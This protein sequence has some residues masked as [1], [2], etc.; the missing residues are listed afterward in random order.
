[1]E[2]Q[3]QTSFTFEIDNFSEKDAAISSPTFSTGRFQWFVRVHPKGDDVDDHLSLYLRVANPESLPLGWKRR[4][5]ISFALLNQSGKEIFRKDESTSYQLFCAQLSGW[6]WANAVPLK[7]LQEEGFLEKNKLRVKVEVKVVEVVDEEDATGNEMFQ[8]RGFHVLYS[9]ARIVTMLFF[10]HPDIAVNVRS[11]NQLVKTTYMNL[12][13]GLIETLEKPTHSITDSELS[14]AHSEL[15][16]LTDVAGFKLDWLKTKLNEVSLERKKSYGDDT[17]VQELEEHIKNLNV[18]LDKEKV[19]STTSA[20]K[21][22]SLEQTVSYLTNQMSGLKDDVSDLKYEVSDLRDELNKE[23]TSSDTSAA[24]VWSLEK[25][26]SDL[27][28][29]VSDLRDELN[30]EKTRSD[31]FSAEVW[32]LEQTVSDLKDEVSDLK[33]ALNKEEAKSVLSLEHTVLSLRDELKKEETKSDTCAAKVLSLEQTVSDLKDELNKEEAKS[34]ICA[35]KYLSLEQTVS[36]LKDELNK[37]KGKSDTS[38][39][40]VLSLE[41]TVLSLRDE[42]KKENGV[43]SSWEVLDYA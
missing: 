13:L 37:E 9:Q 43:V 2:D 16:E 17:E 27:K 25:T 18:E 36:N 8:H 3:K 20:A 12:L 30:K 29:E 32:S 19:K 4:A 23:K 42:L 21:V 39:A 35:A 10:K 14:N 41:Q 31:T 33:D 5:S 34:D 38:T 24:E 22:L 6:G 40:K 28:D 11:K 26:V 7:K 15:I 1:M